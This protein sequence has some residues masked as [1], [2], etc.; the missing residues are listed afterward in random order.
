MNTKVL[1]AISGVAL[2]LRPAVLVSQA[3]PQSIDLPHQIDPVIFP[4]EVDFSATWHT[5]G[6][7]ELFADGHVKLIPQAS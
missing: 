4:L 5:R 7:N 2:F 1:F 3:S 6:V